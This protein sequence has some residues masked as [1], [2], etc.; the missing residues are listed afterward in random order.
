MAQKDKLDQEM[1]LLGAKKNNQCKRDNKIKH[2]SYCTEFKFL[3]IF[4]NVVNF[5]VLK[6][7]VIKTNI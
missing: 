2:K 5:M 6:M 3:M 7:I 1:F 4:D